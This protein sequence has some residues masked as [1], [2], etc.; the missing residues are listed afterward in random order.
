ML[1]RILLWTLA[2]V[3]LASAAGGI[4]L[5][6]LATGPAPASGELAL[7]GLEQPVEIMRD[8][9][10]VPHVWASSMADA[11]FAQGYLHATDRLWQ[12]EMFR[13]VAQGRLSELFGEGTLDADRFLR[14]LGLARAGGASAAVISA[15]TRA[16]VEAYARGVNAAMAGWRGSLPPEFVLLR[17]SF[18]SWEIEHSLAVE[19]IMAWD[20]SEY[21]TSTSLAGARAAVGDEAVLA[22]LPHYPE[23]GVTILQDV[24]ASAVGDA[25]A[26]DAGPVVDGTD[27]L[28]PAV[29]ADLVASARVPDAARPL[30]EAASV[31][32]A[33][34]SWVVGGARTRSG[35]P[36]V[37]ND[38]HLGLDQ[39]NIWY[40]LGLH[41]PGLDVVGQSLPGAPGVIA[42]HTAGVAW[43]Y[44]NA[45]VDDSDLF[46]ERVD[47]ADST[48]YLTPDGS[49]PFRVREESIRVRGHEEPVRF[50]V[51]ETRHGPVMT[52]VEEVAGDELLSYRWAAHGP[53]TTFE[54][55]LAMNRANTAADLI[56]AMARFT[57][58]HQN[59][60]FAD[61][62]GD[63][64]YWL[65][66]ALPRRRSGRPPLLPVPGW[67]GEHDWTGTL[68]PELNPRLL[69]P[70][71]GFVASANN[72]QGW[73]SLALLISP[74]RWQEPYRAQRITEL[75][76]ARLDHDTESMRAIQLDVRS[77]FVGR[78]RD[79]ASAAFRRA[80]L[81][82]LAGAL[83]AWDGRASIEGTETTLF[84]AWTE[85]LRDRMRTRFYVETGGYGYFPRYMV[86]RALDQGGASMD[87]LAAAAALSVVG[88]EILP[89]GSAH[90]LRVSHPLEVVPVVG[91]LLG[92]GRRGI[93]RPGDPYTVNVASF[94]GSVPPFEVTAGPSQRSV[95]DLADLGGGGGFILPGGQSGRPAS[96]H[97]WDQFER[98]QR[99]ELWRLPIDR[100]AVEARTV[101]RLILVPPGPA[102]R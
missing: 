7:P 46:I 37:A 40:L 80:G 89:W 1:A 88:A 66:G 21:E 4:W 27:R 36:L 73:D 63:F 81:D 76:E 101:A 50:V 24:P 48:R 70:P 43:G 28:P 42:G 77:G 56:D 10:G 20:L 19:K 55:I 93:A 82:S 16:L 98:W 94:S 97:A 31:V 45:M 3:L 79:Q 35:K 33:S 25:S 51:R 34:N 91:R 65:A 39:P 72:R 96:P 8:S 99:G 5:R 30:L 2:V 12:M 92:F 44:T 67:S 86:E 57:G 59:V 26:A 14:T 54:A 102:T 68:P 38:M 53:S 90:T 9:L 6:R 13:R 61:T 83:D 17:A 52:P 71:S 62:A 32:R 64:G 11:V 60:V 23:W 87:S 47:P 84:Y 58:P 75:I 22:L 78:Y 41:A 15:D 74:D 100:S 49:E 95:I 18:E 85:S 69:D 29:S